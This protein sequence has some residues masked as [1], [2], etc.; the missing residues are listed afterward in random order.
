MYYYKGFGIRKRAMS[1][2]PAV[3][4]HKK[5]VD[6]TYKTT[7]KAQVIFNSCNELRY[8]F[9]LFNVGGVSC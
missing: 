1:E 3:Y 4:M 9:P 7:Q 5:F 2:L 8:L 6:V